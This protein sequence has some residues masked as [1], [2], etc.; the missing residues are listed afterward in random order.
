MPLWSAGGAG[1]RILRVF[2]WW[3]HG[4]SWPWTIVVM[5]VC[6]RFRSQKSSQLRRQLGCR[7]TED[8]EHR[9]YHGQRFDW[10]AGPDDPLREAER[11]RGEFAE[12]EDHDDAEVAQFLQRAY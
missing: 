8:R 5:P 4:A 7:A 11:L 2:R 6:E 3:G 9:Q 1:G 10:L 12:M